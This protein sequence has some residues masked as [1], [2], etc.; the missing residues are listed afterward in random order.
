MEKI[1]YAALFGLLL[2]TSCDNKEIEQDLI[3]PD[4][5]LFEDEGVVVL[6][7]G[8][9]TA[10]R[11]AVIGGNAMFSAFKTEWVVGDILL[12]VFE[13]TIN[14]KTT[15]LPQWSGGKVRTIT[16]VDLNDRSRA[17][18]NWGVPVGIDYTKPYDMF[19]FYGVK[20]V[21][22][23][24]NVPTVKLDGVK[25]FI[26][27]QLGQRVETLNPPIR[28][29]K[30]T[31]YPKGSPQRPGDTK[32]EF[33][34]EHIGSM[35]IVEIE[36]TSNAETSGTFRIDLQNPPVATNPLTE[37]SW[38]K[39]YYPKEI[40]YNPVT[41]KVTPDYTS[42]D[43]AE[44]PAITIAPNGGKGYLINWMNVRRTDDFLS[45]LV[46]QSDDSKTVDNSVKRPAVN[47][48]Y[49]PTGGQSVL[50]HSSELAERTVPFYPSRA[51]YYRLTW[52]GKNLI[53]VSDWEVLPWETV[54]NNIDLSNY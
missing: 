46:T 29:A 18:F 40:T 3:T 25:E 26:P 49:T 39:W 43:V 37:D 31:V 9:R 54:Q 36:N 30:T 34:F 42:G 24:D 17:D 33:V 53:L 16:A 23:V 38:G 8:E 10:T 50:V 22:V 6:P 19:V 27:Y 52:D 28:S 2:F 1:L 35:Q 12:F 15:I 5:E 21:S 14:G 4:A 11:V 13:Q 51:Y 7:G 48:V 41:N 44:S 47:L 20:E 32:P 45:Y